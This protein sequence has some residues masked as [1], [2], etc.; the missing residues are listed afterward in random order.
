MR[1]GGQNYHVSY[2]LYAPLTYSGAI[3]STRSNIEIVV[4][5]ELIML[6]LKQRE[7]V[8][9]RHHFSGQNN[10]SMMVKYI[11]LDFT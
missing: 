2:T 10:S 6:T 9:S 1:P 3:V 8:K 4:Y 11:L 7:E 5:L